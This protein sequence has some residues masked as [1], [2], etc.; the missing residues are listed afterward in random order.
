MF[1]EDFFEK[2]C[3]NEYSCL[4]AGT[5]RVVVYRQSSLYLASINAYNEGKKVFYG[6]LKDGKF[7]AEE[8][9]YEYVL[10]RP[11]NEKEYKYL[12]KNLA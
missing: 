11:L 3:S 6:S 9:K 12:E 7:I 4:D 8:P 2:R 10:K 1:L 5:G